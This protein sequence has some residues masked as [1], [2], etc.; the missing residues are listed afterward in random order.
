MLPNPGSNAISYHGVLGSHAA[1]R[2]EVLPSS[3]QTVSL[4]KLDKAQNSNGAVARPWTYAWADLLW[5]LYSVNTW[6]CPHC[7]RRM[8]LKAVVLP[9]AT[10]RVVDGIYRGK[11]IIARPCPISGPMAPEPPPKQLTPTAP[12]SSQN[13][14]LRKG[15]FFYIL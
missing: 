13:T 12:T 14:E 1:W 5:R 3:P 7:E 11:R 8:L 15:A 10:I 2:R 4:G 6:S 9:P